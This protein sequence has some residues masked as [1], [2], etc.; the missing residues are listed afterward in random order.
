GD[1]LLDESLKFR[2][3]VRLSEMLLEKRRLTAAVRELDRA[4]HSGK[5]HSPWAQNQMGLLYLKN[6]EPERA[7]EC[8]N[9][10]I[11]LFPDDAN[12]YFNRAALQQKRG[13]A[14]LA[15]KD[16]QQ[17]LAVNPFHL[18]ARELLAGL[19][20]AGGDARGTGEQKRIL[21]KLAA[22]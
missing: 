10:V 12:G 18:P 7:L 22:P 11:T 16:A 6:G 21:K 14:A 4:D 20:E 5:T 8:F 3:F 19:L 17:A 15:K 1:T 9:R 13:N 2:K